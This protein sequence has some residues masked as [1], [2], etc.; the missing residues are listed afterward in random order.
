MSIHPS[1]NRVGRPLRPMLACAMILCFALT[2]TWGGV[3][4]ADEAKEQ[5]KSLFAEGRAQYK[6]GNYEA[7]LSAFEQANAIK[8]HPVM[9]LNIGQ[10][11]E[12]MGRLPD[13][14]N[15]YKQFVAA[16]PG[17]AKADAVKQRVQTILST[18]KAGWGV[19]QVETTPPGAEIR[20]ATPDERPRGISPTRVALPAGEHNLIITAEGYNQEIRPVQ[21]GA[22]LVTPLEVTLIPAGPVMQITTAPPGA[23]VIVDGVEVGQSPVS[24]PSAAGVHTVTARLAEHL[25]ITQQITLEDRHAQQALPVEITLTPLSSLGTLEVAVDAPGAEIKVDGNTVGKAPL[26]EPLRLPG[27][28]HRVEAIAPDGRRE[29]RSVD[30]AAG[31]TTRA[32]ITLTEVDEGGLNQR[33]WGWILMGGGGALVAGGAVVGV[34]ALG[35]DGDLD[36]CRSNPSCAGTGEEQDLVD[37]VRDQALLTDVLVFSGAAVAGTGLVLYLLS[38][39]PEQAMKSSRWGVAPTA[40]G[41]VSAF[42]R[43]E[44]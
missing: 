43:I 25:E 13:A 4:F 7:A 36:D 38:D 12:A 19:V 44:F 15:Y 17:Q 41:G 42:G 8:P 16:N 33:D 29:R 5:A 32:I 3:A 34:L 10:V 14:V 11:Y 21:V 1:S 31:Q 20:L 23:T 2:S 18:M 26:A 35:K 6:A 40:G 24:H 9:L 37:S 22:R 30:V 28:A 27:G 39:D